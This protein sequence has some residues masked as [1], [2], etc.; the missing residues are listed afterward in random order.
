MSHK[1]RVSV[2]DGVNNLTSITEENTAS[3]IEILANI[4]AI[5]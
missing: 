5:K 1:A 3:L 4:K 2:V